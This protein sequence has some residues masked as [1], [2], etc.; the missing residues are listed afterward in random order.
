MHILKPCNKLGWV[1][2]ARTAEVTRGAG[3]DIGWD[4]GTSRTFELGNEE[5]FV[6]DRLRHGCGRAGAFLKPCKASHV[7]LVV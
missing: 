5:E 1:S 6:P 3:T 7:I 4:L 2:D